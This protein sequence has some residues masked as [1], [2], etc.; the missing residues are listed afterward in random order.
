MIPSIAI[1]PVMAALVPWLVGRPSRHI[2]LVRQMNS[3]T[4]VQGQQWEGQKKIVSRFE[5]ALCG[6]DLLPVSKYLFS[7][8]GKNIRPRIISAMAGAVNAHRENMMGMVEVE[9]KQDLVTQMCEMYHTASLYHDDVIDNADLYLS[10]FP[11]LVY[12]MPAW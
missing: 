12:F 2:M 10:S 6:T 7:A 8:T 11:S 4:V 1:T 5:A 3:L 9:Q